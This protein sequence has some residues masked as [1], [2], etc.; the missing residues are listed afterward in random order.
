MSGTAHGPPP[1]PRGNI[2]RSEGVKENVQCLCFAVYNIQ[3]PEKGTEGTL[4]RL[5]IICVCRLKK[6]ALRNQLWNL[7]E[8]L[9][10][11]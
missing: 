6:D 3:G 4:K 7:I 11:Q 5:E 2:P 10:D 9:V 8:E 1:P